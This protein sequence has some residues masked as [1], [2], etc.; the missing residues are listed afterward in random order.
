MG[1]SNNT[2]QLA[3]I[4]PFSLALKFF[5]VAIAIPLNRLA[6]NSEEFFIIIFLHV[7]KFYKPATCGK[8]CYFEHGVF[9]CQ[10]FSPLVLRINLS[11][12]SKKEKLLAVQHSLASFYGL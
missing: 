8:V 9:R 7:C 11:R 4:L 3:A 2:P 12:N 6:L 5:F 1:G 10:N